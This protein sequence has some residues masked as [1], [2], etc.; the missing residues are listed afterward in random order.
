MPN[1]PSTPL[2]GLDVKS[3]EGLTDGEVNERCQDDIKSKF[4]PTEPRPIGD[5]LF[6]RGLVSFRNRSLLM[7]RSFID[8]DDGCISGNLPAT[9]LVLFVCKFCSG[10]AIYCDLEGANAVNHRC[11]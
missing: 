8:T 2:L 1:P 5:I 3:D 11:W 4:K 9:S 7:L 6:R 10:G